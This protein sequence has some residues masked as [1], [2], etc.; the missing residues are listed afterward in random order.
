M[1]FILLLLISFFYIESIAQ[2]ETEWLRQAEK[3]E[4]SVNEEGAFESYKKVFRLNPHNYKA[5]WKLSEL[6][7]RIGIRKSTVEA[8]KKFFEAG[9]TYAELAVKENPKGADGYY[10]LSVAMGRL[11]LASSGREKINAVKAI[12]NNAEKAIRLKPNHGLAWHV[13]GK[14]HYEV[15]NLNMFEKAGV[16]I[17]YGGL[18]PASLKESI[19]AYENA[20]KYEHAFALNFLELAKAYNKDDQKTKAIALLKVLPTLPNIISDD[21]RIKK[22]GAVLLKELMN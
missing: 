19:N 21:I 4:M 15:C 12:R 3:Q 1:K 18:P 20:K 8:K 6:C 9:K 10:A 22:E 13:I 2:T 11:A 16:K 5:L 14:W 7:S 17:I